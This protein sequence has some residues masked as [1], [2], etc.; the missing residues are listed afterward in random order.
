[1]IDT[2]LEK[3]RLLSLSAVV[4]QLEQT[5]EMAVQ[6]NWSALQIID[7]L[8]GHELELRRHNRI[9]LR[10]KQSKL[11]EKIT[12][13]QFDFD[14]HPSRKGHRQQIMSLTGQAF[15][16][17]KRDVILIGNP[18]TGKSFFGQ[19][20]RL[21]GHRRP[22]QSVVHHRDGHDQSTHR[23][24]SGPIIAQKTPPLSVPLVS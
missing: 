3:C 7:H 4:K 1:M 14:Y 19:M 6:K 8:F 18:G 15:I 20:H 11:S 23:R 13:D 16:Q 5:L 12:I 17:Q 10:Y 22:S 9:E 2:V 21:F 24:R